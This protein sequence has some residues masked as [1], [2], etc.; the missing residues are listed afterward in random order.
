[1]DRLPAP[2]RRI[3][4]LNNLAEWAGRKFKR[5]PWVALPMALFIATLI[6]A[7]FGFIWDV[8]LHIGKGR[9]PGPLANPAHYFILFGLFLLFIAG[10][11]A[12]VLPYDKPGPVGRAHHPQ[13][14][15]ARRRHPDG[16][17]RPVRAD[18]AFRSTTSGTASS[19]RT[20]RCGGPTHLMMIGGA[21]FSTLSAI[22][23]NHEGLQG[24]GRRRADRRHRLKFVQYLGFGGI[25][26]G[27][28]VYQIEFD[29]GVPQFRQVF[30]PML[31]AARRRSASSRPA[32]CWVAARRSSPRCWRSC[33]AAAWR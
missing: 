29:F 28:S 11:L 7:L 15:R 18:S 25:V 20:S 33:C 22:M 21:G 10:C 24:D 13:L 26:V 30:E 17:L 32:S 23:L 3:T 5:P 1:M 12:C 19:A 4:W 31:I 8:S 6:C 2:Q 27:L 14:V 16:R 9:D